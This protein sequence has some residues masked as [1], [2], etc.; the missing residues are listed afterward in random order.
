MKL[1]IGCNEAA[2]E[3]KKTIKDGITDRFHGKNFKRVTVGLDKKAKARGVEKLSFPE[4]RKLDVGLFRDD[5][6]ARQRIPARYTVLDFVAEAGWRTT[7]V[8]D[9][10]KEG[11]F[12]A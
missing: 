3:L 2:L 10:F 6:F 9:S 8:E 11:G 12:W 1:A 4:I 7:C 5:Q